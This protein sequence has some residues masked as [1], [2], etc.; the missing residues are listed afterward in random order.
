MHELMFMG[1]V[2][3]VFRGRVYADVGTGEPDERVAFVQE[4]ATTGVLDCPAYDAWVAAFQDR[5]WL[6]ESPDYENT[7]DGKV[8][9]WR[10]TLVGRLAL[11]EVLR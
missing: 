1:E 2:P 7:P 5:G 4:L 9:R 11:A 6:P 8:A 10:L 3:E